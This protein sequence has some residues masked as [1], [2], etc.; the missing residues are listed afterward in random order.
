M[1]THIHSYAKTTS[2]ASAGLPQTLP[3]SSIHTI[4]TTYFH[5][6]GRYKQ[7]SVLPSSNRSHRFRCSQHTMSTTSKVLLTTLQR[8]L[9]RS[10]KRKGAGHLPM[11]PKTRGFLN[12]RF[13][14]SCYL[15]FMLNS[16][17]RWINNVATSLFPRLRLFPKSDLNTMS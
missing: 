17:I 15:L 9:G 3:R 7:S 8:T 11:N 4:P 2:I 13:H 16:E 6:W 12:S 14:D 1:F 5:E 10:N